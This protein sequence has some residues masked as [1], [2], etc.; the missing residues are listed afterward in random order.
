MMALR[1]TNAPVAVSV[2]VRPT[3]GILSGGAPAS[4]QPLTMPTYRTTT[5]CPSTVSRTGLQLLMVAQGVPP[6]PP[7][8]FAMAGDANASSRVAV[9]ASRALNRNLIEASWRG[10]PV[11][12]G[13]LGEPLNGDRW[14][15]RAVGQAA[16][17]CTDCSA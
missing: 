6:P 15:G 8:P 7:P 10:L 17:C 12:R 16:G 5:D 2:V 11:S 1:D 4:T 3:T 13:A 9:T 14:R